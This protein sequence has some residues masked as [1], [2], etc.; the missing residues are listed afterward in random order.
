[1]GPVRLKKFW[2][3][4]PDGSGQVERR[5]Q[6]LL[7][8]EAK[9]RFWCFPYTFDGSLDTIRNAVGKGT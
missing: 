8:A 1:L 2:V 4:D 9:A 7:G 5:F 3:F 6:S